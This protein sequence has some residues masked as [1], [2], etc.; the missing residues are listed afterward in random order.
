MG[1]DLRPRR[2]L[3]PRVRVLPRAR[4]A[5]HPRVA[6]HL[7]ALA[8]VHD[9]ADRLPLRAAQPRGA[10]ERLPRRG[11]VLEPHARAGG[12]ADDARLAVRLAVRAADLLVL[13]AV[14]APPLR[15][16]PAAAPRDARLLPRPAA[17]RRRRAPQHRVGRGGA[18]DRRAER[19]HAAVHREG[20]ADAARHRQPHPAQGELHG[21]LRQPRPAAAA[22]A[23]AALALRLPDEDSR[24]EPLPLHPRRDV[25]RRLQ[26][27]PLVHAGRPRRPPPP[28]QL[29]GRRRAQRAGVPVHR[30][31]DAR[32]LLHRA[33]RGA[34]RR[35]QFR[36]NSGAIPAELRRNSSDGRSAASA[37]TAARPP[38]P[39][40][41]TTRATRG[42]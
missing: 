34:V 19:P 26:G 29:H 22:V 18:A 13:L 27:A 11:V 40:R 39:S 21:R 9:R 23:A 24:V 17:D 41:A 42:G 10:G 33:L 36:R 38:P 30:R 31:R 8:R 7:A 20:A 28:V 4:A 25:R 14:D 1:G 12:A 5:V 32:P 15:K 16:G 2:L 3:Q 6:D 37:G 35:A